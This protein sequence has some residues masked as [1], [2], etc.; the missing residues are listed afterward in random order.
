MAIRADSYSST[1]EVKAFTRHLLNGQSTFNSTTR[2]TVT[3]LEKFIDRAS[4]VLNLALS[5]GGYAPSAVRAN[6]TTKLA[7]DDWTTARAAEYTELTQRG[8]GFNDGEGSR[9]AA[10]RNLTKSANEFVAANSLGFVRLGVTQA[11]KMSDG[12]AFT[13]MDAQK[14]R[15]DPDNDAIEQPFVNRRQFDNEGG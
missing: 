14:I 7:C 1:S 8:S 2:P 10:F 11:F 13:G 3:E 6:T 9:T 12:L 5:V 15:T 4:G